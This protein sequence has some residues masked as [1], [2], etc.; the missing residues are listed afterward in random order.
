MKLR[1]KGTWNVVRRIWVNLVCPLLNLWTVQHFDAYC[2]ACVLQQGQCLIQWQLAFKQA[3]SLHCPHCDNVRSGN[4][5][6]RLP[7]FFP[8]HLSTGDFGFNTV[9][10]IKEGTFE[11]FHV[12]FRHPRFFILSLPLKETT[13]KPQ[14]YLRISQF[15]NFTAVQEPGAPLVPPL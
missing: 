7:H 10:E 13:S 6:L 4:K 1:F 9:F 11:C 2:I 12:N 15:R 5:I 8:L 3:S 14:A